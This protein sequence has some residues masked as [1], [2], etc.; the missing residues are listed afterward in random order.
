MIIVGNRGTSV[1]TP[2]VPTPSE[3]RRSK[4]S[5]SVRLFYSRAEDR[6][7]ATWAGDRTA[8]LFSGTLFSD[9]SRVLASIRR[10][11]KLR[12][13]VGRYLSPTEAMGMPKPVWDPT[14]GPA[15]EPP[16]AAGGEA[17]GPRLSGQDSEV[18]EPRCL[19]SRLCENM[20]MR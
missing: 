20:V 6:T 8:I 10:I 19:E 11:G 5:R 9:C 17:D 4:A 16:S 15:V 2:F 13:Q 18:P 1:M 3:S 7:L 14:G 12:K